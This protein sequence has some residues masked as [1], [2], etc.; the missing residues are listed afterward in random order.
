V[1]T[2]LLGLVAAP[3]SIGLQGLDLSLQPLSG[4]L[5]H[6]T[7]KL[8]FFGSVG[9][10]ALIACGALL[11]GLVA[12]STTDHRLRGALAAAALAGI[13]AA[14]L[15]S[16]HVSTAEPRIVS[17]AALFVHVVSIAFWIGSLVPLLALTLAG[18]HRQ[19][20]A[21]FSRTIPIPLAALVASGAALAIT[22][23]GNYEA[24]WSTA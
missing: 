19:A 8:G 2:L 15:A 12:L 22:Q 21:S 4:L 17:R 20:L 5:A 9:T 11:T 3:A 7:W 16:G 14:F 1:A 24:L 6:E 23:L 10:T 18:Q 13:G